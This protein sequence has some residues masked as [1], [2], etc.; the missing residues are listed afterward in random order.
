MNKQNRNKLI[1]TENTLR[2]ARG[3]G[4]RVTCRGA[5]IKNYTLIVAK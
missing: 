2:V 5:G 3:E 1:D 4:L